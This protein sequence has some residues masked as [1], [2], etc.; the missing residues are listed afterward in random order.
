[1]EPFVTPDEV[2]SHLKATRR[3]VLELTRDG[4][5]PAHPLFS[6]SRRKMWRYKLSEVDQ[7]LALWSKKPVGAGS[8]SKPSD[9]I[10]SIGRPGGRKG[11]P[12]G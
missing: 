10:I 1:M 12:N 3:F 6:G 4:I 8:T 2:A 7:A 9:R 5:L 11:K